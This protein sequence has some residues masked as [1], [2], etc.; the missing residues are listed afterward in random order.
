MH[1]PDYLNILNKPT[2]HPVKKAPTFRHH[3]M[4]PFFLKL[5]KTLVTIFMLLLVV[6]KPHSI[7]T[8][9]VLDIKIAKLTLFIL[10]NEKPIEHYLLFNGLYCFLLF[11]IINTYLWSK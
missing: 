1:H 8:K 4:M 10:N 7:L 9:S 11:V 2:L 5:I 6:D 3:I